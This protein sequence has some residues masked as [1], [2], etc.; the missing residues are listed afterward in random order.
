MFLDDDGQGNVRLYYLVSGITNGGR[1]NK[2]NYYETGQIT[3]NSL[4]VILFKY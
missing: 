1:C 4:D 2:Y 3:L